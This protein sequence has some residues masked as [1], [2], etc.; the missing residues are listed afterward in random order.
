M[1]IPNPSPNPN[2]RRNQMYKL[3]LGDAIE[4]M[5]KMPSDSVHLV[6]GSP[7]YED[8]RTY[9]IDFN[10]KRQ[11]WVDWMVEVYRESLRVCKGLVAF[12]VEG[13]TR[14]YSYSG[15]PLLLS[16]DLLRA[17]IT[18]RKPPIFKR[19]GI[20]GSGGPDWLR[21]D[22]EFIVCA[23]NGGKLPWS[24]NTA[25]GH[26]PKWGPGGEMS[27]RV[28]DG[29]RINQ[30]GHSL[31]SGATTV[32]GDGVVRSHGRRPS[33]REIK[34]ISARNSDGT[35]DNEKGEV[36]VAPIKA[37]PGNVVE[38]IVGGGVMGSRL[39]HENEAPFPEKLAEFFVRSFC[40]PDYCHSCGYV[41]GSPINEK[42]TKSYVTLSSMRTTIPHLGKSEEGRSKQ[43]LQ[44]AMPMGIYAE[45][46][47][48]LRLVSEGD[49]T[50]EEQQPEDPILQQT[51]RESMVGGEPKDYETTNPNHEGLYPSTASNAPESEQIRLCDGAS[52]HNG[53]IPE[54]KT[55]GGRDSSP[56]EREKRRQ[57]NRESRIDVE[58]SPRSSS[59]KPYY[60]LSTLP[61][62]VPLE[63]VCPIC[64]SSEVYPGIVLDC[65]SG[66]GT[67]AAVAL[68][69]GRN[70][71]GIDIRPSQIDLA[72]RR[73]E[74]IPNE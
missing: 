55:A 5:R 54:T 47:G 22:Y 69:H 57:S 64:G 12:V 1:A 39:A 52:N 2:Q 37:N 30:W 60:S 6:F 19:V 40:P 62:R 28:S 41:I 11:A 8:A 24:D 15:T 46:Q 48:G 20:P 32:R 35:R 63:Q 10:L 72:L 7:P 51:M 33:H 73:L 27:H 59:E 34:M 25:M 23:T 65:F 61:L 38:C 17:G 50:Q 66:S 58:K 53:E 9:G 45:R 4:E 36:Y 56:S 29:T 70:A 26:P 42:N 18:L 71:I 31:N 49:T 14:K 16:A 74:A 43:V 44:S 21:N 3:I 67:T 68:K 13:K